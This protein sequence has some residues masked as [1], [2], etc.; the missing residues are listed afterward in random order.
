MAL[1]RQLR[2][3]AIPLPASLDVVRAGRVTASGTVGGSIVEPVVDAVVSATGV[4]A[5]RVDA[6]QAAGTVHVDRRQMV[7]KPVDD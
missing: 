1:V 5:G 7:L 3:L 2:A 6:I 4:S